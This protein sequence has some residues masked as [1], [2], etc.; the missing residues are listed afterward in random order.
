[1]AKFPWGDAA[2]VLPSVFIG[3]FLGVAIVGGALV[4]S[5]P[6][7]AVGDT[8]PAAADLRCLAAVTG[9]WV[10]VWYTLLGNQVAVRFANKPDAYKE[11]ASNIA[12][13][14]VVNGQEQ[15]LPFLVLIWL[16]ALFVNPRTSVPL[17]WI[18]VICRYLYPFAYGFYGQM[19]SLVEMPQQVC[20]VDIFYLLYAV[21]YKCWFHGDLHSDVTGTSPA[22][23]FL[24]ALL[25]GFTC[26][27]TFLLV[28]KPAELIIYAGVDWD[29]SYDEEEAG[30]ADEPLGNGMR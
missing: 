18:F 30:S 25:A 24:I 21:L 26:T 4:A 2:F 10:I 22:L 20:Y 6:D 23:M 16:H 12:L 9:V 17:A 11:Q 15:S 19:N 8:F 28:T 13:R 14:G 5:G 29:K 7:G 27:L 1:M 3:L